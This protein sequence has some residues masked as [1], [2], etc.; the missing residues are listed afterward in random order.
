LIFN[1]NEGDEQFSFFIPAIWRE[2]SRAQ[3]HFENLTVFLIA[4]ICVLHAIGTAF[5]LNAGSPGVLSG[6]LYGF[7][8]I[9]QQLCNNSAT[10]P[11]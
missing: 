2:N 5:W 1:G 9:L 11:Q 10:T 7:A 3:I 6:F 4:G 8:M